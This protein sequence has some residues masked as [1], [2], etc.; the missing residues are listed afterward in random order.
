MLRTSGL[1]A[2][3]LAT[4]LPL[5]AQTLIPG[6]QSIDGKVCIGTQCTTPETF[7]DEALKLKQNNPRLLFEDTSTSGSISDWMLIANALNTGTS[8]FFALKEIDTGLTP[9]RI[10]SDAPTNSLRVD[11]IGRIGLGTAFPSRNLHIAEGH[12][13]GIA[14][15]GLGTTGLTPQ[16]WDIV[17]AGYFMINDTTNGDDTP[18]RISPGAEDDLMRLSGDRVAIGGNFW[19]DS[20]LHVRRDDGS[21]SLHV[22]EAST[23]VEPRTLLH[24]ENSGRPEIVLS[25]TDTGGEW[26]FGAGTNFILKQ[27]AVGSTSSAKTKLFEIDDS[28]NAT[29]SGTLTTGGTTCG[30]GCDAVFAPDF[31]LPSIEDHARDMRAL[32]YLPNIGPTPE[33]APIDVTDKLGRMLNELEHAHLYIAQLEQ[34]RRDDRARLDAQQRQ[35][36]RQSGRLAAL[37]TRLGQLAS[38]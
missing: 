1:A 33:G 15:D 34:A 4:A 12:V 3:A 11:N 30:T 18:F 13:P 17:N 21:A 31:P 9:L 8:N 36:D 14:L 28:G 23:T 26:S 27:G 5:S 29:L 22:E 35:I 7:G 24:L 6:D 32:G 2:L 37:E 38:D 20:T 25:N 10:D 16:R 19:T